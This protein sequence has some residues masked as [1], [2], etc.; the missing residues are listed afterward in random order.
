MSEYDELIV[1]EFKAPAGIMEAL[2]DYNRRVGKRIL[3]MDDSVVD[4]AF[5]MNCSW[6]LHA[7]DRGPQPHA[8]DADELLGFFGSDP[9]NPYD[10]GAEIEFW[11]GDEKIMIDRSAL[12]FVPAGVKHCPLL[13]RRVDRPVIHFSILTA[14]E[15]I[16]RDEGWKTLT[17]AEARQC[18]VNEL[19]I[20]PEKIALAEEYNK[21]AQRVIW[22]DENVVPGAFHINTAW[23]RK[24][25][26]T[27]ENVPHEHE[28]DDE[29]I[30]FIGGDPEHPEELGA[31]VEIM[32]GDEKKVITRS[33]MIFVPARLKHCPLVL[34]RVDRPI[35]HFTT[36]PGKRYIKE[37]LA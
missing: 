30:G 36:V 27:V 28:T 25:A 26:N 32:L 4:G 29:I 17:T 31:E 35:F 13:L 10:L 18:V 34:R 22:M 2:P 37:D 24:A 7:T 15:Y 8:H 14:K 6:Y 20:P 5:Q 1:T 21:Y 19:K 3:W 16:T 9:K 23:F 12:V 11:I 33:A